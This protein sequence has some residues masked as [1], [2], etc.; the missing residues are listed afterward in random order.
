M[1]IS[2]NIVFLELS[3]N[4]HDVCACGFLPGYNSML[5]PPVYSMIAQ[6]VKFY[7]FCLIDMEFIRI[8]QVASQII[9][10]DFVFRKTQNSNARN[11]FVIVFRKSKTY[12]FSAM[13]MHNLMPI[14]YS[15]D[16]EKKQSLFD[17]FIATFRVFALI[18]D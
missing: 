18:N 7:V 17:M 12:H 11:A 5:T 3:T 10:K 6:T 16:N 14:Q 1:I 2:A 8:P 13:H 4:K 9:K 15:Q